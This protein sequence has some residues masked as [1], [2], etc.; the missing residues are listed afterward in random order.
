MHELE[1]IAIELHDCAREVEASALARLG[2]RLRHIAD[3]VSDED[4]KVSLLQAALNQIEVVP[5]WTSRL[6]CHT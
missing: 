3:E 4:K 2:K 1:Q 5:M 6:D